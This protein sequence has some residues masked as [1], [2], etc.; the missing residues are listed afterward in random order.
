MLVGAI[1][2]IVATIIY[3]QFARLCQE[4]RNSSSRR[5]SDL[6]SAAGSTRSLEENNKYL[7]RQVPKTFKE[8][9]E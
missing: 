9:T 3:Y 8:D 2:G 7:F 5:V 6:E 4:Y 1:L